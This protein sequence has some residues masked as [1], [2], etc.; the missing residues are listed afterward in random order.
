[1]IN[2]EKRIVDITLGELLDALEL[3]E[4]KK[5]E[6]IHHPPEPDIVTIEVACRITH[7][8]RQTIYQMCCKGISVRKEGTV[9]FPVIRRPHSKRLLFSRKALQ[10]WVE[11]KTI[12][13]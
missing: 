1:M 5:Q 11:G 2:K 3:R 4:A 13:K 7:L 10:Q 8:A 6:V 9:P 12:T